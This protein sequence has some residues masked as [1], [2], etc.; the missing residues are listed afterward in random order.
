MQG[1]RLLTAAW[2]F[3]NTYIVKKQRASARGQESAETMKDN[4][5][6]KG[7]ENNTNVFLRGWIGSL[8]GLEEASSEEGSYRYGLNFKVPIRHAH[9]GRFETIGR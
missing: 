7:Q 9:P 8:V 6:F 4:G 2:M 3:R 1:T 5:Y